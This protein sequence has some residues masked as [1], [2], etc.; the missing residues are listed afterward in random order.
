MYGIIQND[1]RS[2]PLARTDEGRHECDN[3]FHDPGYYRE[4]FDFQ[5]GRV[6]LK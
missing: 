1:A 3:R 4:Y 5:N 6:R 2:R